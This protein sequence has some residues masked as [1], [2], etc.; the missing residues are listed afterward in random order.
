M[1]IALLA[2]AIPIPQQ[3]VAGKLARIMRQ[4]DVNVPSIASPVVDAVRDD[5]AVCPTGKVMIERLERLATAD[6]SGSK[7][8]S[9]S[10]LRFGVHRKT[11]IASRLIGLD[12][13]GD[14]QELRVTVRRSTT[15]QDFMNLP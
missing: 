1:W 5:H 11:R 2:D 3:T 8:F 6:S 12:Q 10:V 7:E 14:P 13:L 9:H 4:A 15:R